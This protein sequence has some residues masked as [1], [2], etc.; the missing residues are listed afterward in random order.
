M[1]QE[2]QAKKLPDDT[3]SL[4]LSYLETIEKDYDELHLYADNCSGRNKNH[5]ISK[6]L[7]ALTDSKKFKKII[8]YFPICGHSFLPCDRDFA[9]IKREL[10]KNNRIY[11][12]EEIKNHI[13]QSSKTK[14]FLVVEAD[15][16]KVYNFEN[17]WPKFYKKSTVSE[18]TS[19]SPRIKK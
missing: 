14:Q 11:G 17:W 12:M 7:Q 8:Q 6:V 19:L 5:C 1:Y 3:C 13:L 4:L 2:G 18:E 9:I 15:H 10:R 16:T